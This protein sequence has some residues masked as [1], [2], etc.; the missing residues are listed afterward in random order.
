MA[1]V[2]LGEARTSYLGAQVTGPAD[3]DER[4][5]VSVGIRRNNQ[6]LLDQITAKM[7]AGDRS[8][9]PLTREEFTRMFGATNE[10][11]ALV[12]QFASSYGL[13]V[14]SEDV[15]RATIHLAGTVAQME[16]AFGVQMHQ[17]AWSHGTYRGMTE[18]P[19]VPAALDGVV[20]AVLGLDTRPIA[21]TRHIVNR[22][23]E[24]PKIESRVGPKA[25]KAQTSYFA[26]Q[27]FA[28][29]YNF[30]DG[31]G[32]GE[33]V[34]IIELGGG[35]RPQDLRIYFAEMGLKVPH[36]VSVSV[37][38]ARNAPGG[39][40]AGADGEVALDIE[41][42]GC[43]A[44]GAKQAVYFAPNTDQGFLDAINAAVY[45]SIN[46]PSVISISW[47]APESLWTS[48]AMIAMNRAFQA[49]T[50]LGVTI[51][52]ASGDNGSTDGMN[53]GAQH[54]DFPSSSPYVA[55]C[56]GT[57]VMATGESVTKE[58]VWDN[59]VPGTNVGGATGGGISS[60]FTVPSYQSGLHATLTAGGTVP[61]TMRGTP[62]VAG[63]ADPVTGYL[64]LV[65][66]RMDVIGGTSAVA[67]LMAALFARINALNKRPAGFIHSAIYKGA[68]SFVPITEGN[69]GYFAAAKPW[70]ATT[71]LGRPDG[72]K[73]AALLK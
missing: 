67:P 21:Q 8:Q 11:R 4:M 1:R 5:E 25:A 56:G 45:D 24:S 46:K 20:D 70:S 28:T 50:A 9:A 33:C 32:H 23:V 57:S 64:V 65:D 12:K 63:N 17:F 58:V 27:E 39:N 72:K 10:D 60:V 16:K 66:G 42:I 6:A 34:A 14:V 26:P 29:L 44:Q 51:F 47:G 35:Y 15:P 30:P 55:A 13:S 54:A 3:P 19:T 59:Q 2:N 37:D 53:D 62:D 52:A 36:V 38:H 22:M 7:T 49:A 31:D 61:L 40:D 18:A 73:L 43:L 68:E 41:V 69:N 48:S 71:G